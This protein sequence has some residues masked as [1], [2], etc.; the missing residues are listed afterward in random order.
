[1][2]PL[3]MCPLEFHVRYF[4]KYVFSLICQLA[5]TSC[6]LSPQ[7]LAAACSN[8]FVPERNGA[9]RECSGLKGHVTPSGV[10]KGCLLVTNQSCVNSRWENSEFPVFILMFLKAALPFFCTWLA[11]WGVANG[12]AKSIQHL[13]G[14]PTETNGLFEAWKG[15]HRGGY[16]GCEGSFFSPKEKGRKGCVSS[17][18]ADYKAQ[19][20]WVTEGV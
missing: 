5:I 3:Q 16:G 14:L 19:R 17:L 2:L 20:W 7:S 11:L 10:G 6:P 9:V 12:T 15:N 13:N 4:K 18:W 8:Q 1:M